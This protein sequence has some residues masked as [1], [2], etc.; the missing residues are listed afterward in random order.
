M[1]ALRLIEMHPH[2]RQ[3]REIEGLA[4]RP[5]QAQIR[6]AVVEPLDAG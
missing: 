5:D 2:R 4:S 3:H 1:S 6:Q